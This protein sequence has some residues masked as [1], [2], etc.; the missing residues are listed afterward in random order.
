MI[1]LKNDT[2]EIILVYL[3]APTSIL[4]LKNPIYFQKYFNENTRSS[5]TNEELER[6]SKYIRL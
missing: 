3:P 1:N 6:L 4:N 2:K 5:V